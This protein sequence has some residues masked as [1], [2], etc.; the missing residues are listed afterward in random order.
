M[1]YEWEPLTDLPANWAD[2]LRKELELAHAQ[3]LKEKAILHDPGKLKELQERLAT[4]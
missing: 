3:W 4:R 1:A 2:L